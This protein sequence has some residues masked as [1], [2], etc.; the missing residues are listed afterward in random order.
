MS[1][2]KPY[3]LDKFLDCF[4]YQMWKST[5]DWDNSQA[6]RNILL[7]NFFYWMSIEIK[8]HISLNYSVYHTIVDTMVVCTRIHK[9]VYNRQ[10]QTF[11][12]TLPS[13]ELSWHVLQEDAHHWEDL[14]PI[15]FKHKNKLSFDDW[16]VFWVPWITKGITKSHFICNEMSYLVCLSQRKSK[17]HHSNQGGTP[18]SA[19]CQPRTRSPPQNKTV[20]RSGQVEHLQFSPWSGSAQHSPYWNSIASKNH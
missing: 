12:T 9:T 17:F 13:S 2:A 11:W 19:L 4:S 20:Q 3:I 7:F 8:W 1:S 6:S 14:H 18:Y 16:N 10:T 5:W 15:F